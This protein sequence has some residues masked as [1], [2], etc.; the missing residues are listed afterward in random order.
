MMIDDP[1][2]QQLAIALRLDVHK[3]SSEDTQARSRLTF[4]RRLLQYVL[5]ETGLL[6][7]VAFGCRSRSMRTLRSNL[8]S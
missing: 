6:L 2:E 4:E 3:G 1:G 8:S 5:A 7:R